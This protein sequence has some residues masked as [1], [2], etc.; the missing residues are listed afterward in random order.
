MRGL[1]L[2]VHVSGFVMWLGGGLASMIAGVTAKRFPPAERLAVY[3]AVAQ[4]HR[5]LIRTGAIAA[6]VSGVAL[7]MPFFQ[8][9]GRLPPWLNMMIANAVLGFIA[10]L[11]VSVPTASKLGALELDPR[12]ELPETFARLRR[13]QV[14]WATLA[15]FFAIMAVVSGTI[16]RN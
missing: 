11:F 12:G 13:R 7:A 15:G 14:I 3:R 5:I 8:A 4:V 2:F 9:G 16:V 10:L 1:W 6:L